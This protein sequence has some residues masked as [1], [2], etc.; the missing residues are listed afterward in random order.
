MGRDIYEWLD[1]IGQLDERHDEV[2]DLERAR[3][4]ASVQLVGND[5]RRDLDL[6]ALR[7]RGVRVVG[8]LM[9][10]EEDARSARAGSR[11]SRKTRT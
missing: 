6:N 8:R 2:E 3:R 7:D 11:T 5:A 9:A 4:H 10:A 1:R